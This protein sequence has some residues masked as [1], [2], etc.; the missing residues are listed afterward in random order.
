ML[1]VAPSY[2]LP[3]VIYQKLSLAYEQD[4]FNYNSFIRFFHIY[5]ATSVS[6]LTDFIT[7]WDGIQFDRSLCQMRTFH[8]GK[9]K[10]LKLNAQ[11]KWHL[12]LYTK[13]R[14]IITVFYNFFWS[15]LSWTF[16]TFLLQVNMKSCRN[17]SLSVCNNK[18][19]W[20]VSV[21][22]RRKPFVAFTEVVQRYE[23]NNISWT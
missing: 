9:K 12:A 20:S 10:D 22:K 18:Q 11:I 16:T 13:F 7:M 17:E 23:R 6:G 19:Y 4:Q 21:T 3:S 1:L 15:L 8:L 5:N 14:T 2:S